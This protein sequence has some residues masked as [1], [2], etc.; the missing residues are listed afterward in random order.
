[1]HCQMKIEEKLG[2][3]RK[4]HGQNFFCVFQ[5]QTMSYSILFWTKNLTRHGQN[6]ACV[7]EHL[8]VSL[9]IKL[10][11]ALGMVLFNK[12]ISPCLPNPIHPSLFILFGL[13]TTLKDTYCFIL[14]FVGIRIIGGLVFVFYYFV[15]VFFVFSLILQGFFRFWM[16]STEF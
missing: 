14:S 12:S 6:F 5:P 8:L 13:W 2:R 4:R 3:Y 9:S 15:F 7:F 11:L 10:C 1:M 16:E